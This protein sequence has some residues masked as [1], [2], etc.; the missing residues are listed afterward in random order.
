MAS[1]ARPE[2]SPAAHSAGHTPILA[3]RRRGLP[4]GTDARGRVTGGRPGAWQ[5]GRRLSAF[6][7]CLFSPISRSFFS[8]FLRCVRYSF[9]ISVIPS[10]SLEVTHSVSGLSVAAQELLV[11]W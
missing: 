7:F 11:T 3:Q 9:L 10:S 2:K 1:V 4:K 6:D 8:L 5:P